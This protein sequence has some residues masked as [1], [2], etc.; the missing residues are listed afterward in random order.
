MFACAC[1]APVTRSLSILQKLASAPMPAA[2]A[3]DT[4]TP[5]YQV[6]EA[7]NRKDCGMAA[8]IEEPILPLIEEVGIVIKVFG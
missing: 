2:A 3:A 6:V 4:W 8:G 7:E 1:F 5:E